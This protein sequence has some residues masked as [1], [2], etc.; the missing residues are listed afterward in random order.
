ML[1]VHR[2]EG[3]E[4]QLEPGPGLC[5]EHRSWGTGFGYCAFGVG[6]LYDTPLWHLG[7]ILAS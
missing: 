4:A 2:N 5:G 1:R 3:D 6:G 7:H